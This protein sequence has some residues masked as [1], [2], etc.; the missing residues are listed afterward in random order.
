MGLS[1]YHSPQTRLEKRFSRGLSGLVS[2]TS[3]KALTDSVDHLSTSGAGNGVDVGVSRTP[4]D[5]FN[6][7]PEYGLAEFDVQ[8]RF[9]ASAV[10]MVPYGKGRSYGAYAKGVS[11]F[12]LGGW[13]LSP[14]I[15]IQSGLGLT[16]LQSTLL[17]LGG[18]RTSRPNRLANGALP[19]DQR[20]AERWFDTSAF[21][22]LQ[23][24]PTRPGFVP[25]QAFGNS[26]VGIM[27]GVSRGVLQLVQRA[28]FGV[29]GVTMGGGFGE[30][31]AMSTE[32]RV[33]QFALKY[34][35]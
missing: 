18:E 26:G 16:A 25:N 4:Q 17:N 32:P 19:Q 6:R 22:I 29:P 27:R 33:I 2:Y 23:T 1:N 13:E 21:L 28:N 9:V 24:D 3:G 5:G 14:I 31:V 12:L 8:H 20:T 34:K 15:T 35:F 7:S 10:Y 30:I 11:G